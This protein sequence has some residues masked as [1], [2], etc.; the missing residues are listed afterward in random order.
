MSWVFLMLAGLA[1]VAFTTSMKLSDGFK[2]L[3]PSLLFFVFAPL[4]F[5]CLTTAMQSIPLGTAYAVWTGIGAVG[6]AF[7]G[8]VAFGESA[9]RPRIGLLLVMIAAIVGLKL[10]S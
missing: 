3:W 8:I 6:T 2:K 1:E 10:V 4:S 5:W 7:V 9:N